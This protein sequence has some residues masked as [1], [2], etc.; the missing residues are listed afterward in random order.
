MAI[1]F[2]TPDAAGHW[3]RSRRVPSTSSIIASS[4]PQ[5]LS[6]ATEPAVIRQ[7]EPDSSQSQEAAA[8]SASASSPASL[9]MV[10]ASR[11]VSPA[12]LSMVPASS[13][14]ATLPSCSGAALSGSGAPASSGVVG[15][16]QHL[17]IETRTWAIAVVC[18]VAR[19]KCFARGGVHALPALTG[20]GHRT[21]RA[22]RAALD[23][24][25]AWTIPRCRYVASTQ[26]GAST[27]IHALPD[28]ASSD[29]AVGT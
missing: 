19:P 28:L 13:C 18:H 7:P 15:P 8:F 24:R 22:S 14:G 1:R 11:S 10:P 6:P 4:T 9:V 26:L 23:V 5:R 16:V 29:R 25:G 27:S 2:P 12:S 20:C 21:S 17:L 3:R